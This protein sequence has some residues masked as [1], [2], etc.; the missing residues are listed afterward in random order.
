MT[1]EI[2][3]T[4]AVLRRLAASQPGRQAVVED[5]TAITYSRFARDL[6]RVQSAIGA[7]GMQPGDIVAVEWLG[8]YRHW[9]LLLAL[10]ERGVV[11]ASYLPAEQGK[12]REILSSADAVV[13]MPEQAPEN[14]RDLKPV[15]EDWWR[16]TLS[17]KRPK[18]FREV[19][20]A[21]SMPVRLAQSSGTTGIRKRML[22]TLA[23]DDFRIGLHRDMLGLDGSSRFLVSMS[24]AM[25]GIYLGAQAA[26]RQGATIIYQSGPDSWQA[27]RDRRPS[28]ATLL[29]IKLEAMLDRMREPVRKTRFLRILLQG[30]TVSPA[31]RARAAEMLGAELIETYATNEAGNIGIIDQDGEGKLLPGVEM[32]LADSAGKLVAEGAGL[33][34]VRSPAIVAGFHEDVETSA[35]LFRDGWFQPGDIAEIPEPG[36]FRLIGRADDLQNY[37]GVKFLPETFERALRERLEVADL[38]VSVQPKHDPGFWVLFAPKPGGDEGRKV[39]Q[40][41][42]AILPKPLGRIGILPVRS[43]PRTETGKLC[44]LEIAAKLEAKLAAERRQKENG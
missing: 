20:W 31:L 1:G 43:L 42:V 29:P 40:I 14:A 39:A 35:R 23:C 24:F 25:Q 26:L 34:Q 27:F 19:E 18:P 8:L 11:T 4:P 21:P 9:L 41:A 3:T 30:G 6:D 28:H 17:L 32:R 37:R 2:E 38:C 36:C 13:A 15:D 33:V 10:A 5:G 16:Q 12:N 7:W 22:R 44:R